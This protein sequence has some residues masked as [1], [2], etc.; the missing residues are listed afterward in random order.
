MVKPLPVQMV[1]V[2]FEIAAVAFTNTVTV[3]VA[4]VPQL[5]VAGVTMYTAVFTELVLLV[6]VPVTK[7]RLVPEPPAD[8]PR[9]TL[10]ANQLYL[11]FAGI[12]FPFTPLT[13]D[14][15][16]G[17]PLQVVVDIS[18]MVTIGLMVTTMEKFPNGAH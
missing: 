12:V 16:K 17:S 1:D 18:L 5:A 15:S 7:V 14:T 11:V 6:N 3:N 9:L 2:I 13:G 4:L 8:K 10:G